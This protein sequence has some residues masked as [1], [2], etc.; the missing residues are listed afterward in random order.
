MKNK[1][2]MKVFTLVIVEKHHIYM[3]SWINGLHEVN[4]V[5]F[6]NI[7][8]FPIPPPQP[9][10]WDFPY[11]YVLPISSPQR[12]ED[13]WHFF[14]SSSESNIPQQESNTAIFT[15]AIA[16][17]STDKMFYLRRFICSATWLDSSILSL[18][19]T[20]LLKLEAW[21]LKVHNID[22]TFLRFT[23]KQGIFPPLI[24]EMF[25]LSKLWLTD[26]TCAS[27]CFR[28]EAHKY[29]RL[30]LPLAHSKMPILI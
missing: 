6:L 3:F 13:P 22:L 30:Q 9:Q 19:H 4:C 11:P 5:F 18:W 16:L 10:L 8:T 17:T 29:N 1:N 7:L 26:T 14:L 27:Y 12:V 20:L 15:P 25:T 23:L 24:G 28:W 21:L 2:I